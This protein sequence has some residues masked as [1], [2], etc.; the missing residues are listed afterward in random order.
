MDSG[1]PSMEGTLGFS[2]DGMYP[3]GILPYNSSTLLYTDRPTIY[4]W[5][6]PSTDGNPIYL[7]GSRHFLSL[8]LPLLPL[9]TPLSAPHCR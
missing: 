6:I 1:L 7:I 8:P 2:L 9:I 5:H 4:G 3:H